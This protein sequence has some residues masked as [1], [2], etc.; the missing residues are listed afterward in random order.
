MPVENSLF[1]AQALRKAKVP[2][3]LHVFEQGPHGLGLGTGWADKI[4]PDPAF[5]A[6]PGL[7]ATWLKAHGFLEKKSK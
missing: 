6:W 7:C 3:E 2:Y 1:F 5:A 4:K